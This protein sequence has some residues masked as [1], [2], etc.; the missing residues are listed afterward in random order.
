[1]RALSRETREISW[2]AL[3][4][5]KNKAKREALRAKVKVRMPARLAVMERVSRGF[6]VIGG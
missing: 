4:V 1:M 6:I 3:L 5:S 2:S